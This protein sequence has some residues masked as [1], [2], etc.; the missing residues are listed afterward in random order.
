MKFLI[1]KKEENFYAQNL[2]QNLHRFTF[3]LVA[4]SDKRG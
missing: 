2:H 1:L 3:F 4:L